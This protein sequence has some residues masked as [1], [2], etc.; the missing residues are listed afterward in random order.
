MFLQIIMALASYLNGPVSGACLFVSSILASSECCVRVA[1]T[2]ILAPAGLA[3]G[4]QIQYRF[5][6]KSYSPA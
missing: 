1:G 5:N 3:P 2:G 6:S 4:G